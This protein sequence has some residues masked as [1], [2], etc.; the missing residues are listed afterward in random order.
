L[1][2]DRPRA[3]RDG[4]RFSGHAGGS[5][6]AR[7]ALISRPERPEDSPPDRFPLKRRADVFVVLLGFAGLGVALFS[8]TWAHPT[9]WS[10][11]TNGDP[12]Q[13]MWFLGW[14]SFA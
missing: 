3:A 12:Q 11:G 13:M 14:G 6:A 10:I 1:P 2:P 7:Q 8:N 5:G 9:S 4:A